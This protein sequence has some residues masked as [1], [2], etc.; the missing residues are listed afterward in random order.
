MDADIA[1]TWKRT[2]LFLLGFLATLVV[3]FG[4]FGWIL[5]GS[6][7]QLTTWWPPLSFPR[8]T[9]PSKISS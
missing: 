8:G 9:G 1:D 6:S 2:G 4:L 3:L 7:A 5:K